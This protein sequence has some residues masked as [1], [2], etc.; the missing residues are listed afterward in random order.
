MGKAI[1]PHCGKYYDYN[2][3][4][5]CEC[6]KVR[7]EEAKEKYNAYKRSYNENNEHNKLIKTA[8]WVKKRQ[9]I[10]DLDG[11]FCQR[12]FYK[13]GIINHHKL[14]VHHIKPRF[15]NPNLIFEDENLITLCKDCNLELGVAETLDFPFD[16]KARYENTNYTL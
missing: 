9:A 7:E 12:C 15:E 6:K 14:Q 10:I 4:E 5:G 11:G 16:F 3:I 2:S 1:C 13:F 8:R